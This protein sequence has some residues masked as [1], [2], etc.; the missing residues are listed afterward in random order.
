MRAT[1]D[2]HTGTVLVCNIFREP[3]NLAAYEAGLMVQDHD[4]KFGYGF[5]DGRFEGNLAYYVNSAN[6][7]DSDQGG[8]YTLV[9]NVKF[10]RV[11]VPHRVDGLGPVYELVFVC[12]RHITAGD[13]LA[14]RSYMKKID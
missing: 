11:S 6:D 12:T 1:V 8:T 5:D 7:E 13:E 9:E 3:F 4:P 2:I 10:H 14:A